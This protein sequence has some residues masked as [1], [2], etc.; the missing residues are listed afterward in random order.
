MLQFVNLNYNKKDRVEVKNP[1][2][3][4]SSLQLKTCLDCSIYLLS[5]KCT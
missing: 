5:Q 1:S 3:T 4:N 2:F